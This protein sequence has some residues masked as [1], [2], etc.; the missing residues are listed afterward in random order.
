MKKDDQVRNNRIRGSV[1]FCCALAAIVSSATS[2]AMADTWLGETWEYAGVGAYPV[3]EWPDE[4]YDVKWI[5]LDLLAG[6]HGNVYGVDLGTIM[7]MCDK[8]CVGVQFAGVCNVVGEAALSAQFAGACNYTHRYSKGI[9]LAAVNWADEDFSGLQMG[10]FNCAGA[11]RGLHVGVLNSAES[12]GGVQL[13]VV[14]VSGEFT[15]VQLGLL[16]VNLSS[17]VPVLPLVNMMF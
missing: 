15:G 8:S 12:G 11:F 17:G 16:N 1:A 6:R 9:Q 3:W 13:G 5:R 7:N 10:M 2:S 4:T 14:N